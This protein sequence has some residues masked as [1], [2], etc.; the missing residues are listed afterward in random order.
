MKHDVLVVGSG[1]YVLGK[2][3]EDFGT[4]LPTLAMEQKEGRIGKII[5][6]STKV[7]S[8]KNARKRAEVL[9]TRLGFHID[10]EF[11]PEKSDNPE[12]YFRSLEN[13]KNIKLGV[14]SVP[15]HLHFKIT[16]DLLKRKISCLVVKPF[17]TKLSEAVELTKIAE[18]KFLW[19]GVEFHKR[20]D[21]A[22]LL[23]RDAISKGKIGDPL[24]FVVEYSQRRIIPE[25]VFAE[26]SNKTNI[27]QYLGVHY[28]DLIYF[29]T[30]ARPIRVCATHQQ[31]LLKNTP[32]AVQANIE[33]E[34]N[35]GERFNSIIITNWIDP[36][37]TSAMSD[38]KIKLIGTEGRIESDQKNRGL[39]FVGK[40]G[41]ED[42]NPYF[43]KIVSSAIG[44]VKVEG[45][46][47]SSIRQFISDAAEV[48]EGRPVFGDSASFKDAL[49]S[50]AVIEAV[51][52]SMNENSSWINIETNQFLELFQ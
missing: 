35:N 49:V 23:M 30:N 19:G 11:F 8:S 15:D 4:I 6:C 42:I 41:I 18:E 7:A 28:V 33:W 52:T 32:D 5:L 48:I 3:E 45:Y 13:N 46:G 25:Q 9:G 43:S 26:W 1:M 51:T 47:P 22:N 20:F 37:T 50:T 12:E 21:R 2:D 31:K 36:N 14:V 24:Y 16:K 39:Q 27:F 34:L 29:L 10:A 38:Q 40:N 44:A 17:T